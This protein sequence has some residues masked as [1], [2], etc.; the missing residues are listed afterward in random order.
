[1]SRTRSASFEQHRDA[2]RAQ[3]ARLFARHGYPVTPIAEL[4]RSC[5]V[6]KA[7][8]YHYYRD[9]EQLLFDIA[10]RYLDGLLAIVAT[11]EAQP[12]PAPARLRQLIER[13]MGAYEDA[14]V[15]HRVL[16]QDVKYLRTAH[17]NQVNAK[18]RRV[19]QAFADAV[20]AAAP[21]LA[22][23][24]L[25]KPVTMTLFGMINWTF[26]WL[27][28][29]GPVGYADMAPVVADLFLDGVGAVR[30]PAGG[31]IAAGATRRAGRG[32]RRPLAQAA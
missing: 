31:G 4:A 8:L 16:V 23:S 6:S 12:Q 5:G 27:K 32:A 30:R 20:A 14:A 25:L 3:A 2:I 29:K 10:D 7:L 22:G 11:V 9:K 18:Q 17:R 26:T 28:D 24:A 15:Y 19:V 13:F 1:M 21:Q